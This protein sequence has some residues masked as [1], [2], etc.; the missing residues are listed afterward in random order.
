MFFRELFLPLVAAILF[1]PAWAGARVLLMPN[2]EGTPGQLGLFMA[3]A[4]VAVTS[5]AEAAWYNPAGMAKESR[6][7][8]AADGFGTVTENVNVR[9]SEGSSARA[10]PG[11]LS[12]VAS[13]SE[14]GRR[15]RFSF[16]S[17]LAW[18]L[19]HRFTTRLESRT[20]IGQA[21]LPESLTGPAQVDALFPDGI[22]RTET[23]RGLGS[24]QVVSPGFGFGLAAGP[25]FRFGGSFR[26]ERVHLE[27]RSET[28]VRFSAVGEQ[29]SGDSL[30][31]SSRTLAHFQGDGSRTISTLGFQADLARSF[32]AG[33]AI[34]FPST[35]ERG[36][37]RILYSRGRAL[38]VSRGGEPLVDSA[39]FTFVEADEVE[40]SLRTP[41]ELRV[42]L[43]LLFDTL[44]VEFDWIRREAL[45]SY[46]VFPA[47][48][49]APESG[50]PFQTSPLRTSL[51][52][53]TSYALGVAL[54]VG[55]GG[56]F[57]LGFALDSSGVPADDPVFRNV[58]F[59]TVSG[60]YYF[61]RGAFAASL[62]FTYRESDERAVNF[63]LLGE[64]DPVQEQIKISSYG[65]H[66]GFSFIL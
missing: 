65:F 30:S 16:G 62:G 14:R 19:N 12:L 40:F 4:Q 46:E 8:L 36:S 54:G 39:D 34:R 3:G 42:G 29:G 51:E 25:W 17:F 21:G 9:D 26:L 44:T 58:D 27:E 43:A 31:G 1:F 2:G 59:N 13:T 6:T 32:S 15:P 18:P 35:D 61:V 11:F 57:L 60:G 22:E 38:S 23:A 64:D 55:G 28:L 50:A 33:L 53:S 20:T 66:L 5:G 63:P 7:L 10:A 56:S 37:G 48:E 41:R 45:G 24:L 49:S 52:G 47:R